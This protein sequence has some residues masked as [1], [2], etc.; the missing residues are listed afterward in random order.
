M[1]TLKEQA[2]DWAEEHYP[3]YEDN[4]EG[5]KQ[6]LA[7][8]AESVTKDMEPVSAEEVLEQCLDDRKIQKHNREFDYDVYL[9]IIEA[10]QKY[11]EQFNK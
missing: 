9:S 1:K 3:C 11:H 4:Y 6:M 7:D 8:F 5:T 2:D 10:M